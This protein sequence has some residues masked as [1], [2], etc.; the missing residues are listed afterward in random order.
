MPDDFVRYQRPRRKRCS[1]CRRLI[2]IGEDCLE[3]TR[4]RTAYTEIEERICGE[5]IPMASLFMCEKCGEIYLNL[6]DI[7]YCL[8]PLDSMADCL[9]HYH[10]LTGFTPRGE[11]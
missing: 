4:E 9:R 11:A 6:E 1:S 8:N 5:E 7:G 3:F 10:E 2:N